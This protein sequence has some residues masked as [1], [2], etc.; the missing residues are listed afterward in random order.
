MI[1]SAK[2]HELPY[3]SDGSC[4]KSELVLYAK[5]PEYPVEAQRRGG[6]NGSA[7]LW[8]VSTRETPRRLAHWR[9]H[10]GP[11]WFDDF[12]PD[13]QHLITTSAT[14]GQNQDLPAAKG[15]AAE[16]KGVSVTSDHTARIWEVQAVIKQE[17]GRARSQRRSERL[18][19]TN[20]YRQ[21]MAPPSQDS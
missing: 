21:T 7:E 15:K 12:T 1:F 19:V 13:G 17:R 11:V 2:Q 16:T 3:F 20:S 9:A 5:R 6:E 10:E 18:K 8:D 14:V 4:A